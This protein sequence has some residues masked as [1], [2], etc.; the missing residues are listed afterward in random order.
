[1]K[2]VLLVTLFIWHS[3]DNSG[4]F[5]KDVPADV[6]KKIACELSSRRT[7]PPS[8]C[9]EE[10]NAVTITIPSGAGVCVGP[11]YDTTATCLE[12]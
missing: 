8:W 11:S 7:C 10:G 3:A 5:I 1:M 4:S 9:D 12:K 2:A 6:C